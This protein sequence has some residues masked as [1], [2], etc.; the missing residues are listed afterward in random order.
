MAKCLLVIDLQYGFITEKTKDILPG[1]K[2]LT[3]VWPEEDYIAATKFVNADDSPFTTDMGWEGLKTPDEQEL[4]GFLR[5]NADLVY[6]KTGYSAVT[7][8]FLS[9]IEENG[10]DEV[11]VCGVDADCCILRTAFDLFEMGMPFLVLK[12]YVASNGGKG[13]TDAAF[14]VMGRAVGKDHISKW[15]Y[16]CQTE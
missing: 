6:E 14:K 13:S 8:E 15:S 4:A 5:A 2:E 7:D 11:D 16:K 3:E 9:F 1:I 10:I 12:K